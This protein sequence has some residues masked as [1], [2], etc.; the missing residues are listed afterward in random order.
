M[1]FSMYAVQG[2]WEIGIVEEV[3]EASGD[4]TEISTDC[5]SEGFQ[6]EDVSGPTDPQLEDVWQCKYS[7][8]VSLQTVRC[9]SIRYHTNTNIDK[10]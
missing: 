7:Q 9:C 5:T 2:S 3:D 10:R 1:Y 4:V 8:S 6:A